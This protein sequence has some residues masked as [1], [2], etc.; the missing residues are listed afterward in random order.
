MDSSNTRQSSYRE[1]LL[2]HLFIGELLRFS[3]LQMEAE[4]EV[5]KPEVDRSGYDVVL[6]AS[7]ITRHVQLKSSSVNAKTAMQKVHVDLGKKPSGCIVWI[8]FDPNTLELGPFLF[9]GGSPGSPLPD[10]GGLKVAHHTKA[11]ASGLK[12]ERPNI[13]VVPKGQ[14]EVV[15]SVPLL[16]ERLFGIR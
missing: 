1:K 5:S 9:F 6:E 12:A 15:N 10:L 8:Q 11:N 2:E 16:Y 14:F 4:L 3:W 13:R 7:G